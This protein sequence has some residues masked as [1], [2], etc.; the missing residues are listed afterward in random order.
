MSKAHQFQIA[1]FALTLLY[2][3]N[4][5]TAAPSGMILRSPYNLTCKEFIDLNNKA[6]IGAEN[7]NI[8]G[9]QAMHYIAWSMGYIR[10]KFPN[11]Y[12]TP[13]DKNASLADDNQFSTQVALISGGLIAY[14]RK[15]GNQKYMDAVDSMLSRIKELSE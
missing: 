14:C 9:V 5:V 7:W 10:A 1:V 15:D 13:S 12:K 6:M 8:S 3:P 11:A 2:V 4:V